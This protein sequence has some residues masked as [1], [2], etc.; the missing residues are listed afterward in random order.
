MNQFLRN[1]I[2]TIQWLP[3]IWKDVDYDYEGMLDI[4]QYKAE[5]IARHHKKHRLIAHWS[6]VVK[7]CDTL[8][9]LIELHKDDPDDEYT[10]YCN[11]HLERDLTSPFPPSCCKALRLSE[12]RKERNWKA[13]WR[14]L[15]E[16]AR[17]WWD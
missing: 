4:L 2:R 7:E 6:H 13:I 16:N 12:L 17:G 14:Y 11:S 9:H 8:W 15:E 10:H 3:I 1:I 5:R